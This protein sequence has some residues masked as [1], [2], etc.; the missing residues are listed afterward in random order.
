VAAVAGAYLFWRAMPAYSGSEKLPG[1]SAEVHLWRDGYGVSHIFAASM[2]DAAR[3]LGYLHASE[4]LCSGPSDK[5]D[6]S[7]TPPPDSG[8][9]LALAPCRDGNPGA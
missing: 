7:S 4:R 6:W 1:L 3:A 5:V 2:D 8:E 9:R